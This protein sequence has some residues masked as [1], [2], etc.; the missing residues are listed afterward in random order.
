MNLDPERV[1][2]IAAEEG[3]DLVRF[4][5]TDPAEHGRHFEAWL[6]AGRHGDMAWIAEWRDQIVDPS[7]WARQPR[8]AVALAWDYGRPAVELRGGGRVAR[9][10]ATRDY[11]RSLGNKVRRIRRS[12][13]REGVPFGSI[14]IGTDAIPILE[15]ALAA[16]AGIGFLA[17]SA[18]IISPEHG[19]YLL[20]SELLTPLELPLD[21]PS[22]GS[23]GSCT[24]CIDACP[25]GAIVAPFQVDARRCISH[26]TIE[27]RAPIPEAMREPMGS[28]LF[29]C[30][31]CLEVCPFAHSRG[32]ATRPHEDLP[33]E[34]A[35]HPLIECTTLIGILQLEEDEFRDHWTGTPLRRATRS[36]LRRNAAV[37]LGNLGDPDSL[38]ALTSALDDPD[39]IVRE[40]AAWAIGR[41]EPRN[42]ALDRAAD[43][44]TDSRVKAAIARARDSL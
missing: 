2:A 8:S 31:V 19:P 23:C 21:L 37:V 41:I 4:G 44:E 22:P 40:H 27:S 14:D 6:D 24:R 15:R 43:R 20:L 5:P 18:G 13:E 3:F 17:K 39:P 25:T 32:R 29:G 33:P 9:Y 16:R 38:P 34:L 11:H 26:A 10:A 1:R 28:W 36:G 35:L 30:D 42:P 7:T 12:L